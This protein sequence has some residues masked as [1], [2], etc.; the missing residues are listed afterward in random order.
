[1]RYELLRGKETYALQERVE[2]ASRHAKIKLTNEQSDVFVKT[3]VESPPS[4]TRL[5]KAARPFKKHGFALN[6]IW[7][8]PAT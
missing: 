5:R 6:E 2:Q 3:R 8:I 7:R 4:G 1:M